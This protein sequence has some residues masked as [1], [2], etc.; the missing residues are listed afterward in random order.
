MESS[1]PLVIQTCLDAPI[2]VELIKK[3][4]KNEPKIFPALLITDKEAFGQNGESA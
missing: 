2:T 1:L 4:K 3:T